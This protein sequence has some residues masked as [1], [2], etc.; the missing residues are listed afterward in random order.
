MKSPAERITRARALHRR[1]SASS[2]LLLLVADPDVTDHDRLARD[3]HPHG[4]EILWC[5][6]GA[7]ALVAFGRS[8]PDALL[9]APSLELVDAVTVVRT[10]RAEL[11]VPVL[12]RV[13]PDD[14][15][16]AGPVLL[17]GASAIGRA[18]RPVELLHHLEELVPN[19]DER[20]R[21]TYGPLELD[22]RAYS[23]HLHGRELEELPLKEFELLR[24]L[25]TYA[26]QVVNTEQISHAIWG[27]ANPP[28]SPNTIAVHIARLRARLG[29]EFMIKRIRGRGYR[30][31]LPS[32][33]DAS[34][35]VI[36]DDARR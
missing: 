8:R 30:L 16:A 4:V 7:A 13:G 10:V 23:V 2:G 3:L 1:W 28:P 5:H 20:V 22:P 6:D 25:M 35:R 33:A 32:V 29:G 31:T 14:Y 34:A 24:V 12:V 11:P 19:L 15:D 27:D 26:D 36:G 18:Y 21:L 9:I 17:A